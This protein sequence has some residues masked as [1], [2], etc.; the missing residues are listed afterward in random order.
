MFFSRVSEIPAVQ[1]QPYCGKW[2]REQNLIAFK[3]C[4]KTACFCF[5]SKYAFSKLYNKWSVGYYELKRHIPN[6]GLTPETYITYCKKA[7]NRSCLV[8]P[9]IT[10]LSSFT[11]LHVIPNMNFSAK[12]K[13]GYLKKIL[14]TIQFWFP[15]TFFVFLF[16]VSIGS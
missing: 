6:L 9:E 15:L 10:I 13:I 5:H 1:A 8:R 3:E 4:M 12:H 16:K 7:H 14:A 2:G 11:H